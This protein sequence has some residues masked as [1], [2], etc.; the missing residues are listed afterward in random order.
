MTAMA[1]DRAGRSGLGP[2]LAAILAVETRP[3]LLILLT[4]PVSVAGAWALWSAD[5]VLSRLAVMDLL[6]NLSGAWHI[7]YGDDP[8]E[9]FRDALGQLN[10]RLTAIGFQLTGPSVRAFLVGEIIM[11]AVLLAAACSAAVP[12]LPLVAAAVFVLFSALHAIVPV[13]VG[14]PLDDFT[15]GMSYNRYGWGALGILA[16]ILFVPPRNPEAP[17][18]LDIAIGTALIAMMFYLKLTYFIVGIGGLVLAL[19]VSAHVKV[20]PAGWT[21]SLAAQLG[22]AAA[23]HSH[24]Y[25]ADFVLAATSGFGETYVSNH[26][27]LV[28]NNAAE[29]ALYGIGVVVAIVLWRRGQ[30]PFRLPA[31]AIFLFTG[32]VALLAQNTQAHSIPL[33]ACIAFLLYDALGRQIGASQLPQGIV[34]GLLLV[35]AISVGAAAIGIAGYHVAAARP[36]P[37][38]V[39]D[40]TNLRGLAVPSVEGVRD[41]SAWQAHYLRTL[42]EAAELFA[43]SDGPPGR[44]QVFDRV[45]PMPFVLGAPPPR[46]RDL[47]WE[48]G[49]PPRP[50]E[51][52]LGD[53]DHALIPKTP[54]SRQIPSLARTHYADYLAEHFPF[55]HETEH[56]TLL[57]R[58][59]LGEKQ[60]RT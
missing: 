7:A 22:N 4:A 11:L 2:L 8:H 55:R 48:P 43:G 21:L 1:S 57:S 41:P 13:N 28:F 49:M 60:P 47:W 27:R 44:V 50:A 6:Y 17:R 54:S 12:R 36:E 29:S 33:G 30:A 59:P 15:F 31:A 46:G 3:A 38:A 18:R 32:G 35:P 25:L 42:V 53:A 26:V 58:R 19:L 9:G 34:A 10:F 39:V 52:L 14:D 51:Q 45:N 16:L 56:W 37:L 23:P 40:R 20:S 24:D 5:V